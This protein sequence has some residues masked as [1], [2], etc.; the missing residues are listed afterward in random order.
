MMIRFLFLVVITLFCTACQS[1]ASPTVLTASEPY[2]PATIA[3]GALVNLEN[4][5]EDPETDATT[6]TFLENVYDV[7]NIPVTAV[8]LTARLAALVVVGAAYTVTTSDTIPERYKAME[9]IQQNIAYW[10]PLHTAMPNPDQHP[11]FYSNKK[12][13]GVYT[14]TCLG[15]QST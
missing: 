5:C 4:S 7:L 14:P 1:T 11:E 10:L 12:N 13:I 15:G 9:T 3:V 8:M 6:A 2:A